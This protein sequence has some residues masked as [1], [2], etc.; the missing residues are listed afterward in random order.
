MADGVTP[1]ARLYPLEHSL[2][3]TD[4]GSVGP[5]RDDPEIVVSGY[6]LDRDVNAV[7]GCSVRIEVIQGQA[8]SGNRPLYVVV[9]STNRVV[10]LRPID[11]RR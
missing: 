7:R 10:V 5:L 4:G 1:A 3:L 6:A 11:A 9:W 2:D 8:T